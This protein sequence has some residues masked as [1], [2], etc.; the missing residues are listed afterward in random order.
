MT[1]NHSSHNVEYE[2]GRFYCIDC[3]VELV[4][5]YF[6]KKCNSDKDIKSELEEESK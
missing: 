1:E 4:L 5:H 6:C 2:E 3:D